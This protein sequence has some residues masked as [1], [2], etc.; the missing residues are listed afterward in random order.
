MLF[1]FI[2]SDGNI[3]LYHIAYCHF[4]SLG[5]LLMLMCFIILLTCMDITALQLE[6]GECNF[7]LE[8]SC[9]N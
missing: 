5:T 2:V 1:Y 8:G 9:D 6:T 3:Y 4:G 7:V